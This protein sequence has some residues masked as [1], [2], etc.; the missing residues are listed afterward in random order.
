MAVAPDGTLLELIMAGE[1]MDIY[2][3]DPE[4]AARYRAEFPTVRDKRYTLY[5]EL[6][7]HIDAE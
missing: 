2:D 7:G 6:L 3:I 5:C 4:E 1:E